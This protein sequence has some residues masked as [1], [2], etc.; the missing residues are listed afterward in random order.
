MRNKFA[1]GSLRNTRVCLQ[2]A[3]YRH[4]LK[5]FP[6]EDFDLCSIQLH[7][8]RMQETEHRRI[9]RKGLVTEAGFKL[10]KCQS[11]S[12]SSFL[13]KR[14]PAYY[15]MEFRVQR[16]INSFSPLAPDSTCPPGFVARQPAC[17]QEAAQQFPWTSWI[18]RTCVFIQ[19]NRGTSL[20]HAL[21][22]ISWLF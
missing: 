15:V 18:W 19:M 16:I 2:Q 10:S 13:Q 14:C 8:M 21:E 22:T 7:E 12:C 5:G 3:P 4:S 1:Y 20:G 9:F 6:L 11:P 17:L